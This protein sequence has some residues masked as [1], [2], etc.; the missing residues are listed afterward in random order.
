MRESWKQKWRKTGIDEGKR[1]RGRKWAASLE[2]FPSPHSPLEKA[3]IV[4]AEVKDFKIDHPSDP[5][6]QYLQ[7]TSVE[8]SEMMNIYSGNV[9]TDELGQATIQLP[10][11]FEV[12]N[13]DFRYQLTT[14]GRDAHA[15]VA[16]E[17]SSHRFR[18]A[19]NATFVKVSWQITAVRQDPFAKSHPLVVELEKPGVERGTY[20]HPELYGQPDEKR[21]VWAKRPGQLQ[22]MKRQQAAVS[23]ATKDQ[24]K[25]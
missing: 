24:P 8:S 23:T 1:E 20:L 18:I 7:H 16:E 15:W 4:D 5:A 11:W 3:S 9:T 13:G 2:A 22:R 12:E 14:I 6:N 10:D 17:V 19:T 21:T 25:E